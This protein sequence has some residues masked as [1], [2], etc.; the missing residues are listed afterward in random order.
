MTLPS[1]A[2]MPIGRSQR[3]DEDIPQRIQAES[4][5]ELDTERDV[6]PVN[7]PDDSTGDRDLP[8]NTNNS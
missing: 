2:Q 8:L 1:E 4:D 6:E 7:T 3:L 5:T